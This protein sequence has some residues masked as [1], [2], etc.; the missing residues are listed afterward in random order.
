M[1]TVAELSH[2]IVDDFRERQKTR[3]QRT[4]VGAEDATKAKYNKGKPPNSNLITQT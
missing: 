2:G 1:K 3:L 4:F